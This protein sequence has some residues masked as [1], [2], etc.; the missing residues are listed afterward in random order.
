MGSFLRSFRGNAVC[1]FGGSA[2]RG[3][4]FHI[5][6]VA[7]LTSFSSGIFHPLKRDFSRKE[8]A[9]GTSHES[10]GEKVAGYGPY[11]K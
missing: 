7:R 1:T 2:F 8:G 9:P 3:D 11:T 5:Q 6:A 4:Q 10:L